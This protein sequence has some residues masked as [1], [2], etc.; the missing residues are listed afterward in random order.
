[1]IISLVQRY[2]REH[3][4]IREIIKR[5]TP[6]FIPRGKTDRAYIGIVTDLNDASFLE[7]SAVI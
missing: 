6:V 7:T 2:S 5:N 4:D 1:M 3:V